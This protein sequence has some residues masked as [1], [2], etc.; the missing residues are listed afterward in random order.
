MGVGV[1]LGG[2]RWRWGQI[3]DKLKKKRVAI[4]LSYYQYIEFPVEAAFVTKSMGVLCY[5]TLTETTLR[6]ARTRAIEMK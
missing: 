5:V 3:K 6:K 4:S 2:G 1:E